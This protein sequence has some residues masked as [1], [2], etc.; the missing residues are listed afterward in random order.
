MSEEEFSNE[1][2][3]GS[4]TNEGYES[5]S[6]DQGSEGDSGETES[7][8][9]NAA[10]AALK[11]YKV[12]VDGEEIEVDENELLRGYQMRK[13][14]DKRFAE[15]TQAR[16]QAEEFVRL[17]KT[18]PTKVLSHPSIGHDVK[19][20][21]EDYLLAELEKEMMT[22]EQRQLKEY[23]QKLQQ[24][25][26]MEKRQKEEYQNRQK[27]A[28]KQRYQQEYN[29]QIVGALENSGLPKTEHTVKRMIHYMY[30]ALEKG[31]ELNANDVVDLVK[32][33]YI[34]DTKSL[35]SGLDSE[36]LIKILGDDVAKK[37]RK[38]ELNQIKQSGF[39][40]QSRT[41]ST[42]TKNNQKGPR[43]MNKDEWREHINKIANS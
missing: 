37:L 41:P 33:D 13:A 29:Q 26:E 14:S 40:P 22:P 25:E 8:I 28:V 15:A 2:G 19:K 34:E 18:D 23:Q 1:E 20:L 32:K 39:T 11:K 31:Y 24:Y 5:L 3:T 35:Y 7:A 27:E 4:E 38:H 10:E 43:K 16:K 21:A 42:G 30:N 36:A 17:L 6:D 9:K 12:K